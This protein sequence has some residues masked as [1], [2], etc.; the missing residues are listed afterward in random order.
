MSSS[1]QIMGHWVNKKP[2]TWIGWLT[3]IIM[4]VS[5]VAAIISLL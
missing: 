4:T 1:K 5:G 2:V 3:T